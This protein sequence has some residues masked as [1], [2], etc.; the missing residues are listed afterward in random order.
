MDEEADTALR[1]LGAWLRA[2]PEVARAASV[3]LTR[4]S[5]APEDMGGAFDAIQVVFDDAVSLANLL[6]AYGTWRST[7]T[8]RT[9]VE[10]RRGDGRRVEDNDGSPESRQRAADFLTGTGTGTGPDDDL[11]DA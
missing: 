1:S 2:D 10:F 8:H 5:A 9:R 6:I 7:R 11:S 3:T 4:S